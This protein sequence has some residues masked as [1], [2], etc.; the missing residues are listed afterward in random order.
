MKT[1]WIL[2]GVSMVVAFSGGLVRAASPCCAV[3]SDGSS[4]QE[5]LTIP[6]LFSGCMEVDDATC[7]AG[8]PAGSCVC[9]AGVCGTDCTDNAAKGCCSAG[10]GDNC[11]G[12]PTLA[13][14]RL[15][16]EIEPVAISFFAGVPLA[17]I[18]GLLWMPPGTP[19]TVLLAVHGSSG[20]KEYWGSIGIAGYSFADRQALHGRAVVAIDLPGYRPGDVPAGPGIEGYATIVDRIVAALRSGGYQVANA[21][22]P[23]FDAVVGVGWSMGGLIVDGTEGLFGSFD[24]IVPTA[25]SHGGF[26]E[27]EI[28]CYGLEGDCPSVYEQGFDTGNADADVM[29]HTFGCPPF[30]GLPPTAF[31]STFVWSIPLEGFGLA[32]APVGLDD[33]TMT[34]TKPVLIILGKT[35]WFYD[36]TRLHEEPSHFPRADVTFLFL[37]DTGHDVFH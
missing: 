1:R 19:T 37:D 5:N 17:E 8:G 27:E 7:V 13:C 18:P 4:C 2:L 29:T 3:A 24:A 9:V 14:G 23:A 15:P 16:G 28:A 30:V 25:W 32:P 21:S 36:R 34:I 12:A 11:P 10:Q 33:V 26:S 31:A 6:F 20:V 35:D 22:A